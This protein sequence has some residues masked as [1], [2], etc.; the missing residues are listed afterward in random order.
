MIV[1]HCDTLL[2]DSWLLHVTKHVDGRRPESSTCCTTGPPG[3]WGCTAF[4]RLMMR[5][6]DSEERLSVPSEPVPRARPD[7]PACCTVDCKR[8]KNSFPGKLL[9]CEP[10]HV[11]YNILCWSAPAIASTTQ[12]VRRCPLDTTRKLLAAHSI[13]LPFPEAQK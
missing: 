10:K 4:L 8:D 11:V 3:F 9:T 2:D 5:N 1:V 12:R 13:I 6:L 7:G